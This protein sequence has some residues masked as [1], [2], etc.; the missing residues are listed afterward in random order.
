MAR[1]TMWAAAAAVSVVAGAL[2]C[3]TARAPSGAEASA[4]AGCSSCHSGPGEAPPFRDSTGGTDPSRPAIGAHDAHLHGN[5]TSNISCG[6]CHGVPRTVTDPGHLEDSPEDVRFGPLAMARSAAPTYDPQS[7]TCATAYCHG[8]FP[9]GNTQN[10]PRWTAGA[11]AGECGSC[12]GLPPQTGAHAFHIPAVFGGQ[13]ITCT[14]CHGTVAADTHVNGRVDVALPAW[15]AGTR[16][17][18]QACHAGQP[19]G[20]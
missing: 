6:D 18:G 17:C 20:G 2:G 11:A 8:N 7:R 15:S 12:H 5:L 13:A 1:A 4:T 10:S 19:W 14:T 3:G 16:S 9:G